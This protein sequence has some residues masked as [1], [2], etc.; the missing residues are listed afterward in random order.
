MLCQA[1]GIKSCTRQRIL[2]TFVV[3]AILSLRHIQLFETPWTT[4]CQTSLSFTVSRSLCKLMSIESMMPSTQTQTGKDHRM[5]Y[6]TMGWR[7]TDMG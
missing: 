5:Q 2:H 1:L 3:V 4:A 6:V 7:Q